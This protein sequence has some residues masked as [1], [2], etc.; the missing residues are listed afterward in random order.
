MRSLID[1]VIIAG[2]AMLIPAGIQLARDAVL[3]LWRVL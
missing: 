2:S 1:A 3:Q